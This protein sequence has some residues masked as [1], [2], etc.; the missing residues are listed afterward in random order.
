MVSRDVVFNEHIMGY[1][2]P[3]SPDKIDGHIARD[4]TEVEVEALG[5][6][7]DHDDAQNHE[8]NTEVPY[9][10]ETQYQHDDPADEDTDSQNEEDH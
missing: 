5:Q 7:H 9:D 8:Q 6:A 2:T 3:H 10:T 1:N 4:T